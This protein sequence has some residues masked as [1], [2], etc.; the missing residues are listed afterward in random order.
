MVLDS[1]AIVAIHL[2]EPGYESLVEAIEGAELVVIG[3]PTVLETAMVLSSRLNCDARPM[4]S[5]FLRRLN[6]EVVAFG[7]EH[8]ASAAAAFLRFG[9]GRHPAAL[10]LGDCMSYAVASVAG[11]PLLFKG[12]DFTRTDIERA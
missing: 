2:K 4:I 11:L 12:E 10:N 9:R 3:A 1:S 6:A 7:E 8:W 5:T